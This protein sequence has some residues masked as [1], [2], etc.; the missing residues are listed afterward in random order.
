MRPAVSIKL[1]LL[2]DNPVDREN[3]R[4][5]LQRAK[6]ANY[7]FVEKNSVAGALAFVEKHK[8]DCI[9]LD[10][11]L[12]DGTGLIFLEQL[13]KIGGTRRFPV[14]MLTGTGNQSIAVQAMKSGAQDYL[15]KESVTAD[16]LHRTIETA[17]YKAKTER[18]LDEQRAE[19][20]RLYAEAQEANARKDHFLA[21]LSH[22][23]RTPLTPVL[24]AVSTK[25]VRKYSYDEVERIFAIIHRNISVEARLIDDML[26]LTRIARGKLQLSL[27]SL[28]LH[29]ILQHAA[30][31][32][33]EERAAKNIQII[34]CLGANHH[35]IDADEARL[36]QVFWN[37][38]KNAIKFTPAAGVVE[39][40]TSN[41][42]DM[43][44]VEITDTGIGLQPETE[45]KIF[46]AFE[47]GRTEITQ[48]FGGLGLGLAISKALVEAHA[49]TI[50]AANRTDVH[51]AIF[52]VILPIDPAK[53]VAAVSREEFAP[54]TSTAKL[55][56]IEDHADS[57]F[58]LK[59]ILQGMGYKV[60]AALTAEEG[61]QA[62]K[63][64]AFDIVISDLGLPDKS[65]IDL[66]REIQAVRKVPAIA[67]SGYGMEDDVSRAKAAGFISHLTKPT[68]IDSLARALETLKAE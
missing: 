31:A 43:V 68:D 9:L 24:A 4:R 58:F 48:R 65:G 6:V 26:D 30:E 34:W 63:D 35:V 51:G 25:D 10:Y 23:L 29:T 18:L 52:Q 27:K 62:Y 59:Q 21:A 7:E 32:V 57:A 55:L 64:G 19:L 44:T 40:T 45:A 49:G 1:L 67:L 36:Q 13:Q 46:N 2:D 42:D 28:E 20:E 3:Y 5:L 41:F 54:H 11:Q 15:E 14:V 53:Q 16:A 22:E 8:P 60:T 33:E 37:I 12:H 17:I 47:Q 66:M 38:L 39:V 56:L 61:L 50:S